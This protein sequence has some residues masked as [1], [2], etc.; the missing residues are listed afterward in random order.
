MTRKE[1]LLKE[2]KLHT[3][4][5]INNNNQCDMQKTGQLVWVQ[6]GLWVMVH[7]C[8]CVRARSHTHIYIIVISDYI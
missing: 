7:V 6:E 8:V 3:A 4:G 1:I 2:N 5:C